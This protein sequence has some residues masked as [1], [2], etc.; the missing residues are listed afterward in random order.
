LR[1]FFTADF[2]RAMAYLD[3]DGI[4]VERVVASR[5][6]FLVHGGSP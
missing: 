6:G 1:A 3:L 2:D 4:F 5:A